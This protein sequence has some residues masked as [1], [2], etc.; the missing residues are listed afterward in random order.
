MSRSRPAASVEAL[1]PSWLRSLTAQNRSP[2]TIETYRAA[3]AA[4][5]IALAGDLCELAGLE[6]AHGHEPLLAALERAVAF[7][8]YRAQDGRSI[9]AAG[10]G[11]A[12]PTR[13]G[14]A[15]IVALPV[16]TTRP[17]SAYAIGEPS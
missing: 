2:K 14:D 6:A 3:A 12:Q 17:L 11:V 7:G 15:L 4:G 8:R 10:T 1:V 13:P 5:N 16:V 9:L